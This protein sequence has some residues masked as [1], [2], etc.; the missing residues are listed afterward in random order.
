MAGNVAEWVFDVYR[1][2][3]YA[4]RVDST[5][6]RVDTGDDAPPKRVVRGGSFASTALELRTFVRAAFDDDAEGV[7]P[8]IGARCCLSIGVR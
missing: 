7:L 8:R 5:D 2:D 3:A 1:N 6:P 4:G